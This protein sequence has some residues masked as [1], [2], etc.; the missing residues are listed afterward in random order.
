MLDG[1]SIAVASCAELPPVQMCDSEL[2]NIEPRS[3]TR[4]IAIH[5]PGSQNGRRS[6]SQKGVDRSQLLRSGGVMPVS[7]P[8]ASLQLKCDTEEGVDH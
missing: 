6:R 3:F 8:M 1:S 2:I 4:I 7:H 5:Q